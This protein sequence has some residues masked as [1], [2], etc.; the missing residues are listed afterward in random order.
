MQAGDDTGT[1]VDCASKHSQCIELVLWIEVIS[2]L[3]QKINVRRLRQY[4][5]YGKAA[6]FAAG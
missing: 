2:W 4:L 6:T 5:G 1:V 3:I